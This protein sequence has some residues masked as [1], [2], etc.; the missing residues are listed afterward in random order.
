MP[1]AY[2]YDLRERVVEAVESGASRRPAADVFRVSASTAIRW[3]KRPLETGGCAA[4]PGGGDQK[5]KAIEAHAAWLMTF[6]AGQP[7]AALREIQTA[8][9]E[10][11]GLEKSISCLWRFY[12]R[13]G[14]TFKKT[15]H[16][17]GQDRPDV[18]VAREAW[19]EDQAG[20]DETGT[21]TNMTRLR[22]R[23][24]EGGRLAGKTPHGH[25]KTTAFIAGLRNDRITAPLVIDGAMSGE[26]FIAYLQQF[27]V[28]ALTPGDIV[29]MDNLAVHKVAG[30]KKAI[31][32]SSS[33]FAKRSIF[34]GR[35]DRFARF[36]HPVGMSW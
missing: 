2:S 36:R 30:V 14:V 27:L 31:E 20:I 23:P 7:D 3:S 35:T 19:R 9:A 22:G 16:A 8:L 17:A 4:R 32:D 34:L 26:A 18:K 5:S 15:L 1:A 12:A 24:A 21:A 25:R 6:V 33:H 10:T 29:V 13:H 11:H 28:P